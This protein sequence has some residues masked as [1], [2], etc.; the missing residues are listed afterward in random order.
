MS[1]FEICYSKVECCY[2]HC[3]H[4]QSIC[5]IQ[6]GWCCLYR[7]FETAVHS[8]L[9]GVIWLLLNLQELYNIFLHVLL[10]DLHVLWM[11][12][13]L[14]LAVSIFMVKPQTWS[15]CILC[16]GQ[17]VMSTNVTWSF[18]C[19]PLCSWE[20]LLGKGSISLKDLGP[21]PSHWSDHWCLSNQCVDLQ[22]SPS[23]SS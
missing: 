21:L 2:S 17:S 10:C 5:C 4:W 13:G 12:S 8:L 14:T 15:G 18:G 7:H 16:V 20:L 19:S 9:Y 22:S 6:L 1:E 3:H 11:W 23:C